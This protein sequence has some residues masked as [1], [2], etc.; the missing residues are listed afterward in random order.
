MFG[1]PLELISMGVSTIGGFYATHTANQAERLHEERIA[2]RKAVK[3]ARDHAPGIWV[4]RFI[5]L[6]MMGLLT[7][8]VVAP[9]FL[10][11]NAVLVDKGWLW[12]STTEIHG[13]IYDDT[14]RMIL[15]SIIGFY[16]GTASATRH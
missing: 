8:I 3:A 12:N 2:H 4:R 7:F 5:V 6:V 9:A 10:D 14:I 15:V 16:F 1:I 13:I 11:I